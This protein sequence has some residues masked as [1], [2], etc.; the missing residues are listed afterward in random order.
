MGDCLAVKRKG[1]SVGKHGSI[2][3]GLF[4]VCNFRGISRFQAPVFD[5]DHHHATVTAV[6]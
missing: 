4:L 1:P 2:E 5:N 3:I 6:I